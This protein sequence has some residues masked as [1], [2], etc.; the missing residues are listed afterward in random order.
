MRRS[1]YPRNR[2]SQRPYR[3]WDAK[4]RKALR[5]RCYLHRRNA[6]NG[7]LLEARWAAIGTALEVYD[8]RTGQLL[9]VYI[10]RVHTIDFKA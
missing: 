10:R 7:A 1:K 9:G 4:E 2:E 6:H 8:S 3:I 5:W